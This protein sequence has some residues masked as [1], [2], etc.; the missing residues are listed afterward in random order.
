[1]VTSYVGFDAA[2]PTQHGKEAVIAPIFRD[3]L[4][5]SIH[6]A[7]V[8]TDAYGTFAGEIPRRE[9]QLN[10]AIAKARAGAQVSGLRLA[11]ASEG[12]IGPDPAFPFVASDSETLVLLD[13][14]WDIHIAESYRSAEIV[15]CRELVSPNDDLTRLM[16]RADFPRH[17]L[18]VRPEQDEFGEVVKGIIDDDRLRKAIRQCSEST[19][20]AII[21]SDFRAHFSPSRMAN[22]AICAERL[23][24]RIASCCP[25]CSAPGWGRIDPVRGLP[26][27]ACGR[28]VE[29]AVRADQQG[30]SRCSFRQE[31]PRPN[32]VVN[33]QWCPQCNP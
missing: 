29:T 6:L 3:R 25:A 9:N 10:T 32:Q 12:T 21:E 28:I 20:K 17:G 8:D 15:T 19:G 14:E 33:P 2:L 1:M 30:C 11:I 23:V 18:I 26:C 24:A 7:A 31:V 27:R 13:I 22:I 4:G 16:V 5:I